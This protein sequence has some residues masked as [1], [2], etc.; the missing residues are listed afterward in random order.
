[1]SKSEQSELVLSKAQLAVDANDTPANSMIKL[2]L[3]SNVDVDKLERLLAL[4]EREQATK[5]RSEYFVALGKF[6]AEV[7]TIPRTREVHSRSGGTMYKFANLDD[8]IR[9][10]RP[11]EQK[12]GFSHRFEYEETAEANGVKV[13]CVVS[14]IGGHSERTTIP[15]PSTSGQNTNAAQNRGI[16][17][18]YG[19]RYALKGAYGLTTCDD[20]DVVGPV[21]TITSEQAN[22][23]SELIM[24][25]GT[26]E[27]KLLAYCGIDVLVDLPTVRYA[28]IESMLRKKVAK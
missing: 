14:H 25:T 7:P 20:N 10:I 21:E 28:E 12:H 26:D 18:S 5:A 9:V 8:V 23:L 3:A 19:E 15:V 11:V 2:A 4:Y 13:T 6:Q 22:K 24:K 1:M 17:I 27:S 16:E